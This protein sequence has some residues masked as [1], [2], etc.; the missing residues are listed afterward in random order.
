MTPP[1][2]PAPELADAF[3]LDLR[4]QPMD[5]LHVWLGGGEEE[6]DTIGDAAGSPAAV[7]ATGC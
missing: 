7:S 1:L 4:Q 5:G 2:A 3:G 6:G